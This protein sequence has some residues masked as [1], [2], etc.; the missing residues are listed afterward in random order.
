MDALVD[1]VCEE[2]GKTSFEALTADLLPLLACCRWHEK[3]AARILRTR[4]LPLGPIW[5]WGQRH[6]VARAP[7][8][9]VAIIATW[10]YPLQLL[11]TQL[12]QA[13]AGGNRV[14]V[15]ASERS[16]RSQERLLRL[17]RDAGLPPGTLTWVAADREAGE[18][19]LAEERFDKVV[20]TGSTQVGRLIAQR[21]AE[22][23]TPSALELSGRDS[24]LVLRDADVPLA[25]RTIL[26]GVAMNAGQT[27]MAP[28]RAIV[29]RPVY[30]AFVRE[31][32]R[33]VEGSPARR[34]V[35]HDEARRARQTRDDAVRAGGRSLGARDE[36]ASDEAALRPLLVADCP[37]KADFFGGTCFAPTLAITPARDLEEA[38]ALH[39]R[40]NHRLATAVFTKDVALARRLAP[41]LGAGSVMINDVV[42]PIAHPGAPLGGRGPSGWGVTQGAEGLLAMTRP[43]H[44]ASTGRLIRPTEMPADEK[45]ERRLR[46]LARLL[47]AGPFRGIRSGAQGEEVRTQEGGEGE[48]D[49]PRR[50]AKTADKVEVHG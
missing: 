50:P 42:T 33:L 34:L 5:H 22:T 40:I 8:G 2:V 48:R 35:S 18:R 12:V 28:K 11:G 10:N 23:L 21:C 44:L 36:P 14:V 25:A 26:A 30:D 3:R 47:Y 4:R 32:E 45:T 31:M 17:A 46:L 20:F 49:V 29:E 38:L 16:P 1:L 19:L 41:R 39:E 13:L 37:P 27:C 15:K 9:R 43:V 7:L 24:A 6:R